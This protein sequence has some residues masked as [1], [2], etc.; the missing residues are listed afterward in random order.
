MTLLSHIRVAWSWIR[1]LI[2]TNKISILSLIVSVARQAILDQV[3]K[4]ITNPEKK[5]AAISVISDAVSSNTEASSSL[6]ELGFNLAFQALKA[7]GK[8]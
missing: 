3:N 4:A 5:S 6:I 7:E 1:P 8:V 2:E